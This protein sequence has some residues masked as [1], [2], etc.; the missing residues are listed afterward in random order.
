[1]AVMVEHCLLCAGGL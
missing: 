1:V